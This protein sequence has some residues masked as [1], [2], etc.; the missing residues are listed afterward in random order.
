MRRDLKARYRGSALG[1]GWS[2]LNPLIYMVVYTVVFSK[3]MRFR[4]PDPHHPGQAFPYAVY[5]LSGLL[6]WNFF[7][8]SV[9]G[10]VNSV[11]GNAALVKKVAF[12]W[13]LLTLSSVIAAFVNYLISL[14]LLVPLL[15]YFKIVIGPSLV[16]VPLVA[17]I[18][19]TLALGLSL[20]IAAGNVYFRDIE[21]LVGIGLTVWFFLTPVIYPYTAIGDSRLHRL[22]AINPMTST[23]DELERFIPAEIAKWARVV[24]DAGIMPE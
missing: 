19:F 7:G 21:Y 4:I 24:K 9:A 10:S 22:L 23:P 18:T 2:L 20:F 11:L 14:A 1:V 16:L 3:F 6:A 17:A 8:N 12:P 13:V 5:L 15:L